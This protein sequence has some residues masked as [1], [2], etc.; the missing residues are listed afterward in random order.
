MIEVVTKIP[1]V[2]CKILKH[3]LPILKVRVGT[4][5]VRV[6]YGLCTGLKPKPE[7]SPYNLNFPR[8]LGP[9][10][11]DTHGILQSGFGATGTI[12]I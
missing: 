10:I 7:V 5:S 2:S 4:D 8:H 12:Q 11:F 9:E 3:V 6:K 1:Q